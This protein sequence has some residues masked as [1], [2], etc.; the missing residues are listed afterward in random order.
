MILAW[1]KTAWEDY[2][3]WQQVDKKTLLRINKLIQ[4]ITRSPFEGLGNPEPLKHQLSGFWSRRIDKEHRLVYQVSDSH[5][6][7]IQCRYHY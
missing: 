3:Y 6:T 1:T 7:I 4:N 2:L 5:L